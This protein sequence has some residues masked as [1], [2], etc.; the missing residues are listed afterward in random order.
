[1]ST[2][3]V[4]INVDAMVAPSITEGKDVVINQWDIRAGLTL[5][6]P[7]HTDAR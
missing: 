1:M 6:I 7:H 5:T 4:K 3:N 2:K